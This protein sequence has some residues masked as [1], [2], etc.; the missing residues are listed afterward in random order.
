MGQK[1]NPTI[2]RLNKTNQ[3]WNS[4]WYSDDDYATPFIQ[5]YKI[6][7][8]IN[9]SQQQLER[10]PPVSF[11]KRQRG[12]L[13]IAL[14]SAKPAQQFSKFKHNKNKSFG[15][16][17]ITHNIL[18]KR[19]HYKKPTHKEDGLRHSL[20]EPIYESN[21]SSLTKLMGT[22]MNLLMPKKKEYFRSQLFLAMGSN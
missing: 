2:L 7:A 20:L 18:R 15:S 22:Q 10:F 12:D 16:H 3:H 9:S 4:C 5:D 1:S 14:F 19:I 8:Y 17:L 21:R 11:V 6:N 13:Q